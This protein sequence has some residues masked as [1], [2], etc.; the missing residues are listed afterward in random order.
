ME[1]LIQS[2]APTSGDARTKKKAGV[3]SAG[4]DGK[5][6][7]DMSI[8]NDEHPNIKLIKEKNRVSRERSLYEMEP[9]AD[10]D[11]DGFEP[12]FVV[13]ATCGEEKRCEAGADSAR[14]AG[15]AHIAVHIDHIV[16]RYATVRVDEIRTR[17]GE[18]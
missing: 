16:H 12:W 9:A 6:K 13:C 1:T 14:T 18:R 15:L 2:I 4:H 17:K 10:A 3:A 8:V 5:A 7:N 11:L